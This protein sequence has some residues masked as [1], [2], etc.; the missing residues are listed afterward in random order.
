MSFDEAF[1]LKWTVQSE[2]VTQYVRKTM[3]LSFAQIFA[4][5]SLDVWCVGQANHTPLHVCAQA[6]SRAALDALI[7]CGTDIEARNQVP[8]YL[9]LLLLFVGVDVRIVV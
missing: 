8:V 2:V 1:V 4:L 5:K 6:G 3:L 9:N 7:R